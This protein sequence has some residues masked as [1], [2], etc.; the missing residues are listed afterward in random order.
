MSYQDRNHCGIGA[1]KEYCT[2]FEKLCTAS[3]FTENESF[4][5]QKKNPNSLRMFGVN[6]LKPSRD[7]TKTH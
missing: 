7:S 1:K 3:I 4:A 5:V 6:I 2:V